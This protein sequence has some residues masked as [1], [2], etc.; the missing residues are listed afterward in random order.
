MNYKSTITKRIQKNLA[1]SIGVLSISFITVLVLFMLEAAGPLSHTTKEALACHC[2]SL[3]ASPEAITEGESTTLNWSF[4]AGGDSG[5]TVTIDK[6]PDNEWNGETG[7]TVVSPTE[8]TTYMAVAH[9]DGVNDFSCTVT[10]TVLPKEELT[11]DNTMV[12]I[13]DGTFTVSGFPEAYNYSVEFCDGTTIENTNVD[14]WSNSQTVDFDKK[15]KKVTA[16][17][18]SCEKTSEVSCGGCP[19]QY[20]VPACPFVASENVDVIDFNSNKNREDADI[21]RSDSEEYKEILK[22]HNISN[23]TYT[24][25]TASWDGCSG[26]VDVLQPNEQWNVDFLKGDSLL[27]TVGP[28]TD[29]AD[30]VLEDTKIDT[31]ANS[32][33][34]NEN[35]DKIRLSHSSYSDNSSTNSVV[36]ICVALEKKVEHVD[37]SLSCTLN[38]SPSR[39]SFG[40]KATISWTS[41]NASTATIDNGIGEVNVNGSKEI[42]VKEG[43]TYTATFSDEDGKSITCSG[44]VS[45][46]SGGGGFCMNCGKKKHH[47]SKHDE[48][49]TTTEK[50]VSKPNI[51]LSKKIVKAGNYI[52]LDKV[53]YTGFKAG[54]LLTAVFWLSVL[55]ISVGIAYFTTNFNLLS[56]LSLSRFV[57]GRKMSD[58]DTGSVDIAFD[59][60]IYDDNVLLSDMSL[61]TQSGDNQEIESLAHTENILLSPEAIKL[62][63]LKLESVEGIDKTEYLKELFQKVKTTYPLEDGWILLSKERSE[64]IFVDEP[65]DE[66]SKSK[67]NVNE[68]K[69]EDN[70]AVEMP[71]RVEQKTIS[72]N[73]VNNSVVEKQKEESSGSVNNL[74]SVFIENL[75]NGNKKSTFELIRNMGAKGVDVASFIGMVV[76]EL[77]KV[78]KNRLEGNHNPNPELV[79]STKV[80]TN[81]DFENALGTL[82][83]CV[84]Y[85]YSNN[86]IGT[87]IALAKIFEHF[88]NK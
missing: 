31:F 39:V 84:D 42:V 52:T 16:Q 60:E 78:Y 53:P 29:L 11:C 14:D 75:V 26:R 27:G 37:T 18:D 57:N 8:T 3:T 6:L 73:N 62:I 28:T 69:A 71:F 38:V 65:T 41:E 56:K 61:G 76:R 70:D 12:D 67:N 74:V 2:E 49:A 19:V 66:I 64:K 15:I 44:N 20:V 58:V 50:N 46:S 23:G 25:K 22:S 34:L 47:T 51:V 36:P 43:K 87:K 86:R 17:S 81:A 54:P 85:S 21:L 40:E 82:V 33:I 13:S 80:W 63:K 72:E 7:S 32:V 4:N 59:D 5:V 30:Y 35:A 68:I 9:K 88:E 48:V 24:V 55:L 77:D 1:I 83:E 45:I 10:V 79:N